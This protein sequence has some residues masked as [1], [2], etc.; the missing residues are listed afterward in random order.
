MTA[1]TAVQ[2]KYIGAV[3][4][5]IEN[6]LGHIAESQ[7]GARRFTLTRNPMMATGTVQGP[8]RQL[9]AAN[10]RNEQIGHSQIR[11]DL[12]TDLDRRRASIAS[13]GTVESSALIGEPVTDGEQGRFD[14]LVAA[15]KAEL[16]S[17]LYRRYNPV[18][19]FILDKMGYASENMAVAKIAKTAVHETLMSS[20]QQAYQLATF[21]NLLEFVGVV[22]SSE[23]GQ[24]VLSDWA[25]NKY[26]HY[27]RQGQDEDVSRGPKADSPAHAIQIVM[28]R[29]KH[30][31]DNGGKLSVETMRDISAL[32]TAIAK[33]VRPHTHAIAQ[34]DNMLSILESD[35]NDIQLRP[36][37]QALLNSL[38]QAFIQDFEP[39]T[40]SA[41]FDKQA[42]VSLIKRIKAGAHSQREQYGLLTDNQRQ[43]IREAYSEFLNHDDFE[44]V[45]TSGVKYPLRGAKVWD[46]NRVLPSQT[47]RLAIAA[48]GPSWMVKNAKALYAKV[49]GSN[50]GPSFPKSG[51]GPSLTTWYTTQ[52]LDVMLGV[53]N[54]QKK[55]YAAGQASDWAANN[56]SSGQKYHWLG[57]HG[58]SEPFLTYALSSNGDVT[59]DFLV[60][61]GDAEVSQGYMRSTLIR[62]VDKMDMKVE[63]GEL[64]VNPKK[65]EVE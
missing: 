51:F 9:E 31:L 13:I 20:S 7:G 36:A 25:G 58:L 39:I 4:A 55:V 17:D 35:M 37:L 47:I 19:A 1:I 8:D 23:Q 53:N 42:V 5:A 18:K 61:G 14:K 29:V 6:R 28:S 52:F 15:V 48:H 30:E 38:G 21:Q 64:K 45:N 41:G 26:Q 3:H 22:N 49:S 33:Q 2:N 34:F 54:I 65:P 59:E 63:G 11:E 56:V 16:K 46:E 60:S 24:E 44:N 12:L 57:A 43:G 10:Y 40:E 32:T 27:I 62:T 50:D